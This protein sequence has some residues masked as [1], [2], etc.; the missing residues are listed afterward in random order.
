[1][2]HVFFALTLALT[3][4]LTPTT[5]AT[6][7]AAD[8]TVDDAW[9]RATAPTAQS[10]VAFLCIDNDGAAADTLLS[11]TSPAADQVELHTMS[12]DA[13]GVMHMTPVE[14]GLAVP[15]HGKVELKPGSYH[16]MLLG[17]KAPL[18]E[19]GSFTLTLQF[20]HAGAVP[21]TVTVADIAA[22]AAPAGCDCCLPK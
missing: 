15:A 10:G 16:F 18:A 22:T 8:L 4:A 13:A 9:S 2:R 1:M 12:K 5:G 14:G 17:L 6:L 20:A 19:K 21:V 7:S 11:A 3:L